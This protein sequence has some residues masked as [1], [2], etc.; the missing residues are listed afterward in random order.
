M[1]SGVHINRAELDGHVAGLRQLLDGHLT[2]HRSAAE[3]AVRKAAIY[4]AGEFTRLTFPNRFGFVLARAT[5]I[6]D[7]HSVYATGGKVFK[8]IVESDGQALARQFYAAY[9]NDNF[10]AAR[11]ILA[12]SRS[13]FRSV[14]L[15]TL[16]PALHDSARS[17]KTGRV[18]IPCPLQIVSKQDLDRY[19]VIAIRR[20]GKTAAGW[21]ACADLLGAP[22]GEHWK[23]TALHGTDGGQI[24][25]IID[26]N[27]VTYILRNLRPLA[28]HHLSGGQV[29]RVRAG[30]RDVLAAALMTELAGK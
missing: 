10:Q 27:K 24:E 25:K 6:A 4:A 20:I 7:V 17:P 30:I 3:E 22:A 11:N 12:R 29:R 28:R 14:P 19:L 2:R 15:G 1:S 9:I 13:R 18:R 8:S 16:N 5:M 23:S 21:S 26:G